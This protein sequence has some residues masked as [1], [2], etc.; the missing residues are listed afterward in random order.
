MSCFSFFGRV[1]ASPTPFEYCRRRPALAF[2]ISV[3]R[4]HDFNR[5]T[6]SYVVFGA[7]T[8]VVNMVVYGLCYTTSDFTT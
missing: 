3:Y 8:T 1:Y 2:T 6:V 4:F 5:E 7:L